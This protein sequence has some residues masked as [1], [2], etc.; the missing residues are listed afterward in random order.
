[1]SQRP[2]TLRNNFL[3]FAHNSIS[4]LVSYIQQELQPSLLQKNSCIGLQSVFVAICKLHLLILISAYFLAF[5]SG[6]LYC[7]LSWSVS[8]L[9]LEAWAWIC[10]VQDHLC[11]SGGV[12]IW[13]IYNLSVCGCAWRCVCVWCV[14]CLYVFVLCTCGTHCWM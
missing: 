9:P 10:S 11:K 8:L 2:L 4:I 12:F 1:M 3:G 14:Y 6:H 7:H 13:C 5:P